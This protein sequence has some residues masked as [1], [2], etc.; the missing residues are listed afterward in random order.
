MLQVL[1]VWIGI[2][3]SSC[4]QRAGGWIERRVS[5]QVVPRQ[6]TGSVTGALWRGCIW[7]ECDSGRKVGRWGGREGKRKSMSGEG[8]GCGVRS[9]GRILLLNP[10]EEGGLNPKQTVDYGMRASGTISRRAERCSQSIRSVPPSSSLDVDEGLLTLSLGQ[11]PGRLQMFSK[12]CLF[13]NKP[14]IRSMHKAVF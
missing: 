9:L 6:P 2:K 11:K 14:I 1:E 13:K 10:L 5:Q 8:N 4:F 7:A 12:F 3:H